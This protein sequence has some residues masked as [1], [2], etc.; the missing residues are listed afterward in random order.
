MSGTRLWPVW[1]IFAGVFLAGAVT[2]G[3]VS[4]RI[5]NKLVEKS[6]GPDQFTPRMMERLSEGLELTDE[7]RAEIKPLVDK[8]WED[9]RI[10][11]RESI[12][13]MKAM[14]AAISK[15]L[16]PEQKAH[17]DEMQAKQREHWKE[18][19]ERRGPTRRDRPEGEREGGAR[20]DTP[21]PPPQP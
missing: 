5:A 11:R 10:R 12:D 3:F 20:R 1:L 15:V 17:Y 21:P 14:E 4:L 2:G 8:A 7:Q 6:R 18:M 16:T 19:T 9:L 13:A